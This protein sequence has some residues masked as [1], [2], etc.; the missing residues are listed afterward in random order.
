MLC[1]CPFFKTRMF[2]LFSNVLPRVSLEAKLS[3]YELIS[4]M[5]CFAISLFTN[6]PFLK[7][8]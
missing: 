7:F 2:F 6:F 5:Y 3:F 8:I 1:N 4:I